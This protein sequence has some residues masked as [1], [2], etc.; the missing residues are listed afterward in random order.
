MAVAAP[1]VEETAGPPPDRPP[2]QPPDHP[3]VADIPL[4]ARNASAD[5]V[6]AA[7]RG[8][9]EALQQRIGV[10]FRRPELLQEAMT[11]AS[12]NNERG[13][14][15][16]PGHDN[17]RL[18]YLGDAVLELVVGEYLFRRFPGDD[19]GRLTQ[20]RAALVNTISLAR[21]AEKLG[22]GDTL[23]LGRGAAKTG[24]SRLPSLLANAFEAMIGS[25]FLD[26]G[27]RVAVRVFLQT[28]GNL[29]D[30]TDQNHKG[31]LQEAAQDR[32]GQTPHYRSTPA[33]GPGHRREYIAE[34]VIGGAVYGTGRGTTKQAAEQDSARAALEQLRSGSPSSGRSAAATGVVAGEAARRGG[35]AAAA[36]GA[37]VRTRRRVAE[38]AA[39]EAAELAVGEPGGS[40]R[41]GRRTAA[42]AVEEAVEREAG[43][44]RRRRGGGGRVAA[45][46]GAA[47]PAA[48][49][50]AD[51]P[52]PMAPPAPVNRTDA[53]ATAAAPLPAPARR[54]GILSVLRSA[55]EAL[56][57]RPSVAGPEEPSVPPSAQRAPD[58]GSP[59]PAASRPAPAPGSAPPAAG[60]AAADPEDGTPGGVRSRSRRGRRG[61]RGRRRPADGGPEGQQGPEAAA[62]E[63]PAARIGPAS[64][65]PGPPRPSGPD[66]G[67]TSAATSPRPRR[68][69]RP[70]PGAG[71]TPAAAPASGSSSRPASDRS[72]GRS[73]VGATSAPQGERPAGAGAVT[74]GSVAPTRDGNAPSRRRR[75]PA[76]PAAP[77]G[78]AGPTPEGATGTP[79]RRPRARR[80]PPAASGPS[81]T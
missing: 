63:R 17:E 79:A 22:L 28:L 50:R 77:G 48:A 2:D 41:R 33:G 54:R 11:H 43:T 72:D 23:L 40:R 6:D 60:P 10:T 36:G 71:A 31:R 75:S 81:D 39:E 70:S 30:W 51:A 38:A 32:L 15:S 67:T 56:V 7:V 44:A 73:P 27:Y 37:S 24:A 29:E 55:A 4:P 52:A 65:R 57:G 61:G 12:W 42:A 34:A 25:I 47:P 13:R 1:A 16:G 49:V 76:A 46:T 74:L 68:P 14:P 3:P 64:E 9:L 5:E 69:R 59:S 26:Q 62:L 20:T 80:T 21:M 58:Q 53:P 35:D 18:E 45:A 19:E 78:P 66:G 8:R